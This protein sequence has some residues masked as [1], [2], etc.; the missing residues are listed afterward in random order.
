[1]E[2][3]KYKN[4][5]VIGYSDYEDYRQISLS[6]PGFEG[7]YLAPKNMEKGLPYLVVVGFEPD[8][9]I[10]KEETNSEKIKILSE[11]SKRVS[12]KEEDLER[13]IFYS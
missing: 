10:A 11:K 1:M 5:K 12:R 9:F 13:L 7:S 8:C 4:L 6:N 2:E 3:A